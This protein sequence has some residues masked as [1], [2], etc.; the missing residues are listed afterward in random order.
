MLRRLLLLSSLSFALVTLVPSSSEARDLRGKLGIGFNNNF[1]S[2][3][4]LS[5]K[6][7]IPTN[8]E[9]VNLQVQ[10]TVGFAFLK[11]QDDRF[12]AG[13]RILIPILAEDNLNLYTAIGAGYVRFHDA[14]QGVRASAVVG[15][16]FFLFGLENLGLSA[17]FGLNLDAGNQILDVQTTGGTAASVGVH[18][19]F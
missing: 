15:V 12:F 3:T 7:G 6:Y 2:L 14:K 9:T 17:E 5:V 11:D 19:Y 10:A 16:E 1:S 18:Y 8:K 13:G 4:S